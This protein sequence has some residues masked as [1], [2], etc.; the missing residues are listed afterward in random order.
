MEW[1]FFLA[2]L[3]A[4]TALLL[5]VPAAAAAAAPGCHAAASVTDVLPPASAW[6]CRDGGW[7][8]AA[9]RQFLR[10]ASDPGAPSPTHFTTRLTRF[11]TMRLTAIGIDGRSASRDV[12]E[13]GM[14]PLS[15]GW[16]MRTALPQLPVPVAAVVVRI[17]GARHVGMFAEARLERIAPDSASAT[18][19]ELMIAALC[20]L[21]C[22][23]FLFNFAFY[24]VLGQ[25]FLVW[26][27]CAVAFMLAQTLLTSGLINRIVGLP[28]ATLC[29][30]SAL[31]FAGGIVSAAL[32]SSDL[33]EPGKLDPLHRRLLAATAPWT[34]GFTLFYLF[35]GGSLRGI[36]PTVY[37]LSFAP[38]LALFCW[39]MTVALWR[40][41][42]SV[43]FQI[44]AWLPF[45]AVG[46]VRVG[47][48]LG[49][50]APLELDLEQHFAIV[51]EILITALGVVDR[52]MV[53][54]RQRDHALFETR[55][56]VAV[57]ERDP[58]TGLTNRRALEQRYTALRDD[59]FT[60]MAVID[61]DHFKAINDTHGHATGDAVLRAVAEALAPDDNTLAV[62]YGG[63]EFILLVRGRDATGRA[64]RR[65]AAIPARVAAA[66][67]GLDRVVTASM[68]L[69]EQAPQVA[70]KRDFAAL[71]A[72]CDRLL[73]EAKHHG[74]NRTV[75]ERLKTFAGHRDGERRKAVQAA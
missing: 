24:R 29:L 32:F 68:G 12:D 38:V 63:E 36:A 11:S 57:V 22:A 71:F 60:T 46:I 4:A 75:S 74:R 72:H 49:G 67:Q 27:T 41:S 42:R 13:T 61:L 8:L 70:G 3:V 26:H 14:R 64:E 40:G 56:L 18:G 43:K 21:L 30:F 25:R 62:R 19:F 10:L 1:R 58:L 17:E 2:R 65:R 34:L 54:R 20:G 39:V 47:S 66:V 28:I 9:E 31:T 7:S 48:S 50:G 5:A 16:T 59:G 69:V 44:A 52:F 37:Y 51:A 35:A 15:G 53:L 23:P 73:Y 6:N 33:I 45:L 55:E